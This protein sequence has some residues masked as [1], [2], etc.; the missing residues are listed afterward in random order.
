MKFIVYFPKTFTW[1]DVSKWF[2]NRGI[3]ALW[4]NEYETHWTA[5][6]ELFVRQTV[7]GWEPS[8][9]IHEN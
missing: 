5:W 8:E 7:H 3:C 4:I 1:F 2:R 9:S 6:T